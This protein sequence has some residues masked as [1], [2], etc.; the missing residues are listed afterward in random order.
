M[1]TV[2]TVF[3]AG[4]RELAGALFE[5]IRQM[6]MG[7]EG[8]TRPSYTETETAAMQV[9]E[10]VAREAGLATRIDA[11]A[12]LVVDLPSSATGK[13]VWVGSHFDSVPEGGN[14]DGL[15]GVIAGLLCL[16]KAK[17]LGY[18]DR[19]LSLIGLR[20]EEAAWFGK[21]YLGSYAFFGAL[22]PEDMDRP[23]RDTGRPMRESFAAVGVDEALVTSKKPLVDPSEIA[24]WFELHIEQG[25]ILE[26]QDL[27]VGV[28]TGIRGNFRHLDA[29][30][31]GVAGHSGAVPR[32]M[33]YDAVFAL[34]HLLSRLDDQWGNLVAEGADL[35]VTTGMIGTNPQEHALS[36]IAGDVGFSLEMRSQS[37]DTLN[38]YHAIVL[39]QCALVEAE[40]GVRFELGERIDTAPAVL[41]AA[42]MENTREACRELSMPFMDI[43]SG[44]GH[45][46][47][48][49]QKNGVPAAMVFVRNQGGSHN[50]EEAMD[51]DDFM[52]GCEVLYRAMT[53]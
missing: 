34:S 4:D 15:A 10:K 28:V 26:A 14:Y 13:P 6:S 21:A 49:F 39:E 27:P 22:T 16:L 12:N 32:E 44:A 25:P 2:S 52:K 33:R 48:I 24:A 45:D 47:A 30:C 17:Q 23:H 3:D 18:C 5:Q 20:G 40:R 37:V 50:P 29:H 1:T 9:V 36:R 11:V 46:A 38:R 53:R 35:V 42:L 19:P 51:L 31:L 7:R 41:D 43:G 8:I